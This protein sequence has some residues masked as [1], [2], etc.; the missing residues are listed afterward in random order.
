[1]PQYLGT[2]PT[3]ATVYVPFDA[4]SGM[5][6]S[7][8]ITGLAVT[9]IEVFKDGSNVQRASDA[10]YALLDGDGIDFD[11]VTGLNGFSLDLSDNTDA[12]FYAAGS[13]Y[14]VVVS[15]VTADGQTVSFVSAIFRIAAGG[16]AYNQAV[17]GSQTNTGALV[18]QTNKPLA[19]SQTNTGALVRLTGKALA[20]AQTNTGAL[21][22]QTGKGL[23][24][25]WSGVGTLVKA[26]GKGLSGAW[27]GSGLLAKVTFKILSGAWSGVGTLGTSLTYLLSLGGAWSGS[28]A[29]VKRTNKILAGA[30]SGTGSIVKAVRKILSGVWSGIGTLVALFGGG[31]CPPY[32]VRGE[33]LDIET[34]GIL[35]VYMDVGGVIRSFSVDGTVRT[36]EVTVTL[37]QNC[38]PA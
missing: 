17:D 18:K 14:W 24:G 36:L 9:D 15:S 8:T 19:G 16:V 32:Q 28:G 33:V 20:G 7:V 13:A 22:K 2:F 5:G 26:T 37:P 34:N 12:G 3:G 27:S 31:V 30:W 10:G 23:S 35:P 38:T 4:Y 29:L 6:A 21:I 11:G 25:A 1:M